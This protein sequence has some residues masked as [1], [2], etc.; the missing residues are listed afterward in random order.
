[1]ENHYLYV[2]TELLFNSLDQ[3]VPRQS[4]VLIANRFDLLKVALAQYLIEN[5]FVG[6]RT[7]LAGSQQCS[8]IRLGPFQVDK[9]TFISTGR[10]QRDEQ[11]FE[12]TRRF[13]NQLLLKIF[14]V[15]CFGFVT[16]IQTRPNKSYMFKVSDGRTYLTHTVP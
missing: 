4:L 5:T 1:M 6:P 16:K 8:C 10:A 2:P 9:S 14:A 12:M 11:A 15:D 7:Q 13:G 3:R